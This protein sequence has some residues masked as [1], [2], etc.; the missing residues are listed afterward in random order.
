MSEQNG[1]G[2]SGERASKDAD[3]GVFRR[4]GAR[5]DAPAGALLAVAQDAPEIKPEM[6]A[7][8]AKIAG[9]PSPPRPR[10]PSPRAGPAGRSAPE[11]SG[12]A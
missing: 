3:S 7:A 9:L 2:T 8:A 12:P 4:V 11:L 5:R 6:V 10:R 1:R